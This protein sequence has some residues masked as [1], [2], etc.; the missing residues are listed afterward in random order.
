MGRIRLH[1]FSRVGMFDE[2]NQNNFSAN[3]QFSWPG[4][5][6]IQCFTWERVNLREGGTVMLSEAKFRYKSACRYFIT[7]CRGMNMTKTLIH[8]GVG[9]VIKV[10]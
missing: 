6:C 8:M 7:S 2:A 3:F 1:V 5:C 9:E 4:A 10:A